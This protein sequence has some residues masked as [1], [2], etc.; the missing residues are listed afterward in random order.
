[1]GKENSADMKKEPNSLVTKL[2]QVGFATYDRVLFEDFTLNVGSGDRISI[3]GRSG[4][5]KTVLMRILAGKEHP[6]EGSVF[7]LPSTNIS[8]VPQE[9]EDIEANGDVSIR[10][11]FRESRGLDDIE[12]RMRQL[13]IKLASDPTTYEQ[14]L[15][16]Y[17]ELSEK[18]QELDGYDPEPEMEKFLAGLGVD[19][20][21]T[22][23]ITLDTLLSNV[24]SGQ[25]KRIMIARALYGKP[26]LMILDDPTSH[27][28]VQAVEWLQNYLK[29]V[30][31]AVVIA[32]NNEEFI[33]NFSNQTIGLTDSGRVFSF[34]GNYA[35]FVTKRDAVIDSEKAQANSV[36]NKIEDLK[37]TDRMFRSKKCL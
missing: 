3:T 26:D 29:R 11:L 14:S 18:F 12:S 19:E 37:E 10:E 4:S 25:L 33:N 32:S 22:G 27:L 16:E 2:D 34:G 30:K 28:D 35:D 15:Q 7:H 6:Q 21:S 31:S 5:G 36:A 9:L 8:Y 17:G 23:N 1:M 13:E 24:S 20:H